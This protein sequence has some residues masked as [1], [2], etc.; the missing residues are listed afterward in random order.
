MAPEG[1]EFFPL[2]FSTKY[3]LNFYSKLS[4]FALQKCKT[5][6]VNVNAKV[7]AMKELK[8]CWEYVSQMEH[9]EKHFWDFFI[10]SPGSILQE[11]LFVDKTTPSKGQIEAIFLSEC[12]FDL[13]KLSFVNKE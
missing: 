4:H 7:T 12:S 3:Q 6:A 8:H 9:L 10:F 13:W 11:I 2:I 5:S 1:T